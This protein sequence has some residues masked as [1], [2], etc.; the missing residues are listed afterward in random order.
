MIEIELKAVVDDL[1]LRRAA[2]ERAGGALEMEGRLEDRR[3]DTSVGTL[4][5]RDHV[6]RVRVF[7]DA[8]SERA[9]LEWKGPVETRDGYKLRE[10]IGTGAEDAAALIAIVEQLGYVVTRAI[11]RDIAQYTLHGA[12]VRFERYPRMDVLVEVEGDRDA[13]ER[14]VT[15]LGMSRDAFNADNLP[16]FVERYERRTGQRAAICDADLLAGKGGADGA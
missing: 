12:K 16:A 7:R 14:A 4:K 8:A 6:L 10:E 9:S 5:S 1:V 3:Y 2:V 11:D 15:A 13:I